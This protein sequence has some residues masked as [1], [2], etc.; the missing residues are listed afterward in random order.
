MSV[1]LRPLSLADLRAL[2]QAE[3]P[4]DVSAAVAPD[5]L[6]PAFVAERALR[7]LAQGKSAWWCNTFYIVRT[8]DGMIVGSCGF[9]DAPLEGRV[10]IGYAV[11]PVCQQQGV[12]TGAVRE[13]LRLAF[14]S[15]E[16]D[17][18]LATIDQTNLASTRIAQKLQFV[19]CGMVIRENADIVIDWRCR[20]AYGHSVA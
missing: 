12:A 11:A 19:D 20:K 3:P 15:G 8:A 1:T 10:E 6:P 2:A 13:L 7:H 14:G 18:V 5:A 9:K 17:E 16:V 4:P